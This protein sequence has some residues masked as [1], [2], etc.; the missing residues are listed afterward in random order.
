MI[1]LSHVAGD[2]DSLVE[3]S[4]LAVAPVTILL[5]IKRPVSLKEECGRIATGEDEPQK[6]RWWG[7]LYIKVPHLILHPLRQ[8]LVTEMVEG[9]E[10]SSKD[11]TMQYDF[12]NNKNIA[13]FL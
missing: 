1:P 3:S 11:S 5:L 6:S 10:V 8:G 9:T 13:T 7:L 12:F 4:S 2:C